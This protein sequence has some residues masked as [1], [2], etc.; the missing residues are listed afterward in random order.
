MPGLRLVA[1]RGPPEAPSSGEGIFPVSPV[2]LVA[3]TILHPVPPRRSAQGRHPGKP[4]GD[5]VA[6]RHMPDR[7]A[8]RTPQEPRLAESERTK[9]TSSLPHR[10]PRWR[11]QGYRPC[12]QDAD[13]RLRHYP[14]RWTVCCEPFARECDMIGVQVYGSGF[15][16][17]RHALI[18]SSDRPG[19]CEA[20]RLRGPE[21]KNHGEGNTPTVRSVIND[22]GLK[23]SFR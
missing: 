9:G 15:R 17:F 10:E 3:P 12:W 11:G 5:R 20:G 22:V 1:R 19:R 21:G 18:L 7:Q 16:S 4:S 14:R 6:P 13:R 23:K 8:R 2:E